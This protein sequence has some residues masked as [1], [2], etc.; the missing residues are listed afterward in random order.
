[1]PRFSRPQKTWQLIVLIVAVVATVL[2]RMNRQ[3]PPVSA[4][5]N[6]PPAATTKKNTWERLE[7]C[8]LA[9]DRNND[10]DSFALRCGGDVHTFRLYFVDCPEKYRNQF[11][12]E[13]IASQGAYFGRLDEEATIAVGVQAKEFTLSLLAKGS[14]TVETR[15]EP[16]YDSGRIYAFVTV[17]GQDLAEAL[18]SRGLARI[19]TKGVT[20]MDGTAE[21]VQ[22][23]RLLELE[24]QARLKKRGAWAAAVR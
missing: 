20:R 15:R 18:V 13:R 8:T 1:M 10:G 2:A 22:K 17:N 4:R 7:H 6:R 19:H 11:N 12:S 16:V 23:A 24:K 21:R 3:A 5:E 9:E 14:V